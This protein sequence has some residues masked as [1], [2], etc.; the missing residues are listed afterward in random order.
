MRETGSIEPSPLE[1]LLGFLIVLFIFIMLL[2][3]EITLLV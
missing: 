1:S 3:T 2:P